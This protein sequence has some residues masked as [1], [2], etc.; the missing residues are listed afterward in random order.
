MY[1][2]FVTQGQGPSSELVAEF[3][4]LQYALEFVEDHKDE[5]SF[6][7]KYPNGKWHKWEPKLSQLKRKNQRWK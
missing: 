6:G 7:I 1:Q 4:F 2:V 5:A 3:K